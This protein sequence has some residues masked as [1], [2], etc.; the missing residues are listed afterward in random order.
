MLCAEARYALALICPVH[1][2]L[3]LYQIMDMHTQ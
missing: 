3:T 2:V 1:A